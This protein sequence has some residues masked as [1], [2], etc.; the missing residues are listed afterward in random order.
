MVDKS[1]KVV[2]LARLGYFARGLIYA[3]LGYLALTAGGA[4][5][6]SQG[7]NGAFQALRHIPAGV[8]ILYVVAAGLVGYAL[9]RLSTALLDTENHGTDAKGLAQR[10]GYLVSAIVYLFL[11][12]TALQYAGLSHSGGG[13]GNGAQK[14]AGTVLQFGLGGVVL[15]IVGIG[16]LIAAFAQAA[17]AWTA[18]F[19]Q[20][21]SSR[22]PWPI[23]WI[24]RIGYATR[25]VVFA[26]IGWSLVHT[27]LFSRNDGEV[28]SLGGAISTLRGHGVLFILLAIGL[29]LFGV[30]SMLLARYRIIPDPEPKRRL[31]L[32]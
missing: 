30:F 24:G 4:G 22:A 17:K 28:K 2:W 8:E 7:A 14:A 11:A 15:A 13:G 18:S 29:L 19:M 23:C 32:A 3:L 27:G 9:F 16:L 5:E 26:I 25:A 10:G 21:V 1:E 12:Y 20:R 6:A 31:G